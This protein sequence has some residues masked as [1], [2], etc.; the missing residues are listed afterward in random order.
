MNNSLFIRNLSWSVS[1]SDLKS[2]FE[3]VGIVEDVRIPQD[4]ETGRPRGFAF[5]TMDSVESATKAIEQLN[6]TPLGDR[7]VIIAYQDPNKKNGGDKRNQVTEGLSLFVKGL[8]YDTDQISLTDWLA[9]AGTVVNVSIPPDPM[10]GGVRDFA[11]IDMASKEDAANVIA[12]LNG[13][14]FNGSPLQIRYKNED[15]RGGRGGGQR[16][17]GGSRRDSYGYSNERY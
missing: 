3:S 5:V 11:F 17:Q 8:A 14:S 6:E 15:R 4:R 10:T 12:Q 9:S 1:E 16:H 7:N 13:Q 2:V